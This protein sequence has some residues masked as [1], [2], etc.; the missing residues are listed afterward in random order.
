MAIPTLKWVKDNLVKYAAKLG[1]KVKES[2]T[3]QEILTEIQ[4]EIGTAPTAPAAEPMPYGVISTDLVA[5]EISRHGE[6]FT[7]KVEGVIV[8]HPE[9]ADRGAFAGMI[10][11][12]SVSELL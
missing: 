11:G 4:K 6:V 8:V 7:L 3:K 10:V 5:K 1:I 2:A 9:K 12:S